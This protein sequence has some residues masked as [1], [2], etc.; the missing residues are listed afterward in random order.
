MR[1]VSILAARLAGIC[2]LA[3]TGFC[4]AGRICIAGN[5]LCTAMV[6]VIGK[7]VAIIKIISGITRCRCAG[8]IFTNRD[9]TVW[10]VCVTS[11]AVAA[12][13]FDGV[14]F[15]NTAE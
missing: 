3:N 2:T 6:V 14:G 5:I 9:L 12:A 1:R 8:G 11:I 7:T 4:V 13:V 15:T 10:N